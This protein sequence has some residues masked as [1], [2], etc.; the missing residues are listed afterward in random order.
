MATATTTT[1]TN[2]ATFTAELRREF[3]TLRRNALTFA[4]RDEWMSEVSARACKLSDGETPTPSDW[5]QAARH[6]T[7]RCDR[8]HGSGV[9]NWGGTVNGK[10]VHT[11]TCYQCG[12]VGRQGQDDYK[13]NYGHILYSISRAI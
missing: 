7:T 9:Y 5:V 8:C 1:T 6:A 10:P 4:T 13:R 3:A 2:K 11:G 12:G